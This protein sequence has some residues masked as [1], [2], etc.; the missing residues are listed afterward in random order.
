MP[1]G[2]IKYHG[3]TNS[4]IRIQ[5]AGGSYEK[6]HEASIP[7][8]TADV[9]I[10]EEGNA[11]LALDAAEKA[12][13]QLL[14]NK[15][16]AL[17]EQAIKSIKEF[18]EDLKVIIQDRNSTEEQR[19]IAA[20]ALHDREMSAFSKYAKQSPPDLKM[21]YEKYIE[22][23]DSL[24][25]EE[26]KAYDYIAQRAS[27]VSAYERHAKA[28]G[29]E[30]EDM[31]HMQDP[32]LL[33]FEMLKEENFKIENPNVFRKKFT[34]VLTPILDRSEDP[35]VKEIA[36]IALKK[37]DELQDMIQSSRTGDKQAM[38]WLEEMTT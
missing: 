1:A 38:V 36:D 21:Y 12:T 20:N 3:S 14:L 7:K 29:N 9:H 5:N 8:P 19:T 15:G 37:F 31:S 16:Q 33:L 6:K 30:P 4:T 13:E 34:D 10:S 2:N 11:K 22:Y 26:K 27:S 25:P 24:S 32:I 23:L 28:Q 17:Y 35:S 18:P